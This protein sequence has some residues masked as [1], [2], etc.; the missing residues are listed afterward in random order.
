M[1]FR[2]RLA[3]GHRRRRRGVAAAGGLAGDRPPRRYR[4]LDA[5]A[6]RRVTRPVAF[7]FLGEPLLIPHLYPI[8][9][10][11]AEAVPDLPLELCVS[12]PLHEELIR[13]CIAAAGVASARIRPAPGVR[14]LRVYVCGK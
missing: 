12:T 11:L 5:R 1:L 6:S 9:E 2:T 7:L 13:C 14:S 10:A 8:V 4:P 3:G